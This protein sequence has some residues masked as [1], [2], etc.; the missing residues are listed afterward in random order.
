MYG[1][2]LHHLLLIFGARPFL[3]HGKGALIL[4]L[5]GMVVLCFS[6]LWSF[7]T[8]ARRGPFPA[9]PSSGRVVSGAH[10]GRALAT[11]PP[12]SPVAVAVAYQGTPWIRAVL[13]TAGRAGLGRAELR[14][15]GPG[16]HVIVLSNCRSCRG[17][18]RGFGC[19]HERG[20][21]EHVMRAFAP[22][23]RVVETA[24]NSASTGACTFEL[25]P[26]ATAT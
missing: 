11:P 10:P 19:E 14:L 1:L 5:G 3:P 4:I 16:R 15:S 7:L 12:A 20:M 6:L 25:R 9:R 26:G 24:C 18:R 23:G 8:P 17:R 22:H 21:L 2:A 13:A